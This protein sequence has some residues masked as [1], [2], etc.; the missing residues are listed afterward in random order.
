MSCDSRVVVQE[1]VDNVPE[2]AGVVRREEVS[3]D[4]VDGLLELHITLVVLMGVVPSR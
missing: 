1:V 2:C 3:L 4:L